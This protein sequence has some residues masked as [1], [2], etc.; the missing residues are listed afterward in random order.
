MKKSSIALLSVWAV[1]IVTG[2]LYTTQKT[3]D[4]SWFETQSVKRLS[5]VVPSWVSIISA[6]EGGSRTE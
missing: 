2:V 5:W 3:P 4:E 1:C 6:D